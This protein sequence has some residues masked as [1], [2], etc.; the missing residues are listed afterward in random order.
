MYDTTVAIVAVSQTY[1][2][3]TAA[4]HD[5]TGA[6]HGTTGAHTDTTAANPLQNR[7]LVETPS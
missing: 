7:D 6:Q 3:A 2:H 5:T 4:F 1:W